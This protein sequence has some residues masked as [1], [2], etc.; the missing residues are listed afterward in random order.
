MRGGKPRSRDASAHRSQPR[1]SAQSSSSRGGL[2][3]PRR[4]LFYTKAPKKGA[5]TNPFGLSPG[6]PCGP[7]SP[8]FNQAFN[9]GPVSSSHSTGRT[10][11]PPGASNKNC[12]L[13]LTGHFKG[14]S[15]AQGPGRE[16]RARRTFPSTPRLPPNPVFGTHPPCLSLSLSNL[17]PSSVGPPSQSPTPAIMLARPRFPPQ[18]AFG[19][20]RLL[21]NRAATPTFFTAALSATAPGVSDAARL[22]NP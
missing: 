9:P 11:C 21:Q 19:G 22:R 1:R 15:R 7:P 2:V 18:E 12:A 10:K 5:S 20:K 6:P 4:P 16:V 13:D 3:Q 17:D 14:S 8:A